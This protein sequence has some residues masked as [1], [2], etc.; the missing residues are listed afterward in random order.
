MIVASLYNF[1]TNSAA[2]KPEHMEWLN[3]HVLNRI[4]P[5]TISVWVRGRASRRGE[6]QYNQ[7]LSERRSNAVLQYLFDHGAWG[8]AGPAFSTRGTGERVTVGAAEN[9]ELDRAVEIQVL[10]AMRPPPPP[11]IRPPVRRDPPPVRSGGPPLT[12]RFRVR[13][14]LSWSVSIRGIGQDSLGLEILDPRNRRIAVYQY[15]GL[16]IGPGTPT[17]NISGGPWNDFTTSGQMAATQFQGF[18]RFGG[19]GIDEFVSLSYLV[20]MGTPSGIAMVTINNFETGY[21]SGAS[22]SAGI[23]RLDLVL[24]RAATPA[25]LQP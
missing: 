24:E 9:D 6:D 17:L 7:G 15:A 16:S 14:V 11:T 20:L 19:I 4:H 25:E 18:A 22:I 1:E 23:G 2:L 8:V 13:L 10:I 3:Q 21:T 5:N 12:N